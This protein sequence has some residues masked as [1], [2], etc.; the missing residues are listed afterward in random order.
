[1]LK[2]VAALLLLL[3][4]AALAEEGP[5]VGTPAPA[6][7][8]TDLAGKPAS[9]KT[10]SGPKGTVLLFFRSAKWCPYCQA[11]LIAFRDA[12]APLAA[13]GYNLAA[14]SY[15]PA[16]VLTKFSDARMI[17][18]PLLSDT[19]S[20][21][22]DAWA[23]RDPQYKPDSFAYGVPRPAIFVISRQGRIDA[24]LM[25]EGYKVRPSVEAVMAA[26]DGLK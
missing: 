21:T 20:V 16:E 13:R 11:Q 7:H 19:G 14:V 17:N 24:K 23:L 9:L 12:A 15:D 10:L 4:V 5:A 22:I 8:A 26:V 2:I 1:M 18:Y 6:L 3:P 25:M